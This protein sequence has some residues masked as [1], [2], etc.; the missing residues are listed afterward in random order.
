MTEPSVILHSKNP[1]QA[2]DWNTLRTMSEE[3]A[4]KHLTAFLR[5]WDRIEKQVY[6]L[7]GMAM[8]LVE[9]RQLYRWVVDEE[10]GDYF[11]SFD[12]WLKQTCPDSWSYC[13]QALNTVKELREIPFE[14][15][16]QIKRC[17]L[18]QL[19]QVSGGVRILPEVVKAAKTLPEKELIAKLN[20]DHAQHLEIKG[21]VVMA[22]TGT[23]EEFE[24]AIARAMERGATT[25]GEA[26]RDISVNYLLD[27]PAEAEQS[28]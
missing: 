20:E 10:V 12:R 2:P 8:L 21:P 27:Y 28:A 25:R 16:L 3:A 6:A 13:R 14:D 4:G 18:E 11:T 15:M 5:G 1:L 19:K 24:A 22:D 26:I 7:R 17:N 23:C 9:E